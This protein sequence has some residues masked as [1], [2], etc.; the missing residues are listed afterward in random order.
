MRQYVR[1]DKLNPLVF[2]VPSNFFSNINEVL[3]AYPDNKNKVSFE[4]IGVS[5]QQLGADWTTKY[6]KRYFYE[7]FD[8][9]DKEEEQDFLTD[10]QDKIQDVLDENHSKYIAMLDAIAADYNPID[11]Y[12]MVEKEIGSQK[13]GNIT[14]TRTYNAGVKKTEQ[15]AARSYTNTHY[16]YPY[17]YAGTVADENKIA[18]KDVRT[19]TGNIVTSMSGTDTTTDV[20]SHEGDQET[21]QELDSTSLTGDTAT[22]RVL[23]RKGNIGVTTT[24]QMLEAEIQ[25]KSRSVIKEFFNDI[26]H[27]I[28]LGI[29]S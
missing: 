6:R 19:E 26:N 5:N 8:T 23:T 20:L 16:E 22:D 1:V 24:Q 28:L 4:T 2:Y 25:L 18:S 9:E 7:P 17:D 12:N 21:N 13:D 11:N 10:I 27:A 15:P 29:W 14:N 3:M